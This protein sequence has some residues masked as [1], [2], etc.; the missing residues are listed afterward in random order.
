MLKTPTELS[1]AFPSSHARSSSVKAASFVLKLEAQGKL[2]FD[3]KQEAHKLQGE[4]S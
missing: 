2:S 1:K 4:R 3:V